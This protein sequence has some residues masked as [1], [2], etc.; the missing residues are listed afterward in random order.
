MAHE[1]TATAPAHLQA[2]F[3]NAMSRLGA[4]VNIVTTDGPAGIS[5]FTATAVCSVSDSPPTLLVCLKRTNSVYNTFKTNKKVCV[6]VLASGQQDIALQFASNVKIPMEDRF[7]EKWWSRHPSGAPVLHQAIARINCTVTDFVEVATHDVM[8]CE[9][10]EVEIDPAH[11]G[12][13]YFDR[14]FHGIPAGTVD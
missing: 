12:L 10:L 7:A 2:T 9:V 3:R 11:D 1:T 13:I 6:N 14:N 8:M 4:A 5:G